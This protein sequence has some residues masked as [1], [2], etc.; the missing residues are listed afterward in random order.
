MLSLTQGFNLNVLPSVDGRKVSEIRRASNEHDGTI[1]VL[2]FRKPSEV[3]NIILECNFDTYEEGRFFLQFEH[4]K[5]E[6][7]MNLYTMVCDLLDDYLVANAA[8]SQ[9]I[10]EFLIG[11]KDLHN[12]S[13]PKLNAPEDNTLML[14]TTGEPRL[15]S[16]DPEEIARLMEEA[17]ESFEEDDEESG[18]DTNGKD[19]SDMTEDQ[20]FT[21]DFF[22][23]C[24]ADKLN[25][26]RLLQMTDYLNVI[27]DE[28]A[29]HLNK[30]NYL[31]F[32]SLS[33]KYDE[34]NGSKDNLS[35]STAIWDRFY[36]YSKK[37]IGQA[38]GHYSIIQTIQSIMEC[39]EGYKVRDWTVADIAHI[40]ELLLSLEEAKD[41]KG[42]EVNMDDNS[43][44][45]K[46]AFV[47][48][49]ADNKMSHLIS[50]LFGSYSG[51]LYVSD[52]VTF[53]S[54]AHEEEQRTAQ[55]FLEYIEDY[56]HLTLSKLKRNENSN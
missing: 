35:P 4:L 29:E 18:R 28:S 44:P 46:D 15:E 38:I 25:F 34:I 33:F 32:I 19:Y 26:F 49:L 21:A 36:R 22:D 40:D 50:E 45:D 30:F 8:T 42:I 5:A 37:I 48:W 12:E 6:E 16:I 47:L 41:N 13:K 52:L 9:D 14:G 2:R 51:D 10:A 54:I 31:A 3:P 24:Q 27:K 11:L 23:F 20:K 55:S 43:I 39:L 56:P 53:L 7:I 1:S 17:F